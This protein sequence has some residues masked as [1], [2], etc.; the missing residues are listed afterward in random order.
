MNVLQHLQEIR[1]LFHEYRPVAPSK[2]GAIAT[3]RPIVTLRIT[4]IDRAQATG[5]VGLGGLDQNM[6][7][8]V[9]T[10]N[11]ATRTFQD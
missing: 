6:A 1:V 9:M 8:M 3:V 7:V 4:A 11:A 5:E 10:Q 2:Q